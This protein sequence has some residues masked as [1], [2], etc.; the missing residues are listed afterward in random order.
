[1]QRVERNAGAKMRWTN[2]ML[3]TNHPLQQYKGKMISAE[4]LLKPITDAK[5]CGDDL[6][7]EVLRPVFGGMKAS[8]L[9]EAGTEKLKVQSS[10]KA[11]KPKLKP[12]RAGRRQ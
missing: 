5:P 9:L 12:A 3:S 6:Y 11:R 2:Q 7:S 10:R 8:A 1:M 4:E